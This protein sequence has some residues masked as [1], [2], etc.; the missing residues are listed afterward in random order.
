MTFVSKT[1]LFK[2]LRPFSFFDIFFIF[3]LGDILAFPSMEY[4]QSMKKCFI[5]REMS[6]F[7]KC[8]NVFCRLF[9]LWKELGHLAEIRNLSIFSKQI[10]MMLY[11]V[12][13]RRPNFSNFLLTL[14]QKEKYTTLWK[15]TL[16]FFLQ[17]KK[18]YS[19]FGKNLEMFHKSIDQGNLID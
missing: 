14:F 10:P 7:T 15:L 4:S 8:C 3:I 12:F 2:L 9:V 18:Q 17:F 13:F 6:I 19:T 11:I 16:L 1:S 5:N